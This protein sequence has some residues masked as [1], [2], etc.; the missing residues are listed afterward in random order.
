MD[1]LNEICMVFLELPLTLLKRI[2]PSVLLFLKF[3]NLFSYRV[4]SKLSQKHFFLLINKLVY[5]LRPL[6][7][8]K[9]H[10]RPS[11]LHG[12]ADYFSKRLVVVWEP[13]ILLSWGDVA[14]FDPSE[15]SSTVGSVFVPNF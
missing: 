4:I 3:I 12:S 6:L 10:S 5:I 8:W 9:L 14:I 15:R 11:S 1:K 13:D 2:L 7:P